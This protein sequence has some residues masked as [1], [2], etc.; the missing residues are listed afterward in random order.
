MSRRCGA[1]RPRRAGV[2]RTSPRVRGTRGEQIA[3]AIEHRLIPASAGNTPALP[4]P[5][6]STPAHPRE[7]GEHGMR[8]TS[9]ASP[10]G[11]SPR[12]RGTPRP[13]RFTARDTRLIPASRGDE[14]LFRPPLAIEAQ[15]C[16]SPRV[17]GTRGGQRVDEAGHRLIPASAGIHAT[18]L[19]QSV[20][21]S[22]SSPRLAGNT[23]ARFGL[24]RWC[25]AHPRECGEHIAAQ[26][27]SDMDS[28]S[29]PRVRGT[30]R[31]RSR[32][33]DGRQ[34]LIPAEC[35]EHSKAYTRQIEPTE[36]IPGKCG[37]HR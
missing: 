1:R 25:P 31:R 13:Q 8:P 30:R 22:G 33:P 36:L 23:R 35:G 29:S 17:R 6:P 19:C 34:R 20:V 2:P 15:A 18:S 21:Q 11:S 9:A 28:G 5:E 10:D 7:C 24:S 16:S 27:G 4:R 3:S 14:P 12:V 37:E 26:A 32:W